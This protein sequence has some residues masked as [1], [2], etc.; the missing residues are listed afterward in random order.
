[1]DSRPVG[2]PLV[3][4]CLGK[5]DSVGKVL[6]HPSHLCQIGE[7]DQGRIAEAEVLKTGD[8]MSP[9]LSQQNVDAPFLQGAGNHGQAQELLIDVHGH[10]EYVFRCGA[11]VCDG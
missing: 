6:V 2:P 1:M 7:S 9:A 10:T 8:S 4:R 5:A 3:L 11:R